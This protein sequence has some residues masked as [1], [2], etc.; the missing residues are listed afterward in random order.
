[1][2]ALLA[3]LILLVPACANDAVAPAALAPDT[4]IVF[5]AP[6]RWE[7]WELRGDKKRVPCASQGPLTTD[8]FTPRDFLFLCRALAA[9]TTR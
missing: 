6:D 7:L 9:T 3:S 8:A 2:R 1:M 5:E 4:L